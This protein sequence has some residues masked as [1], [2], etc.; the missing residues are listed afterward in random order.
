MICR[1]SFLLSY[2]QLIIILL[3]SEDSGRL[4]PHVDVQIGD[5]LKVYYGPMQDSKVTYEAKVRLFVLFFCQKITHDCWF[6]QVCEIRVENS[7]RLFLVHYTG[8]NT[9]YDEW[10]KRVRI[11]ENLTWTPNRKRSKSAHNTQVVR[12]SSAAS[13][14]TTGSYRGMSS[15]RGRARGQDS[16]R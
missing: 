1:S 11:A 14:N 2:L 10:I 16:S 12:N 4:P 13:N 5:K 8:W 6:L 15:K 7:A 3:H 9:R